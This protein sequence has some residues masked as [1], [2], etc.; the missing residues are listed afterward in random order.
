MSVLPEVVSI[1]F[2][3]DVVAGARDFPNSDSYLQ[4]WLR[5]DDAEQ[6]RRP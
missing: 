3:Q 4:S 2:R 5:P 6:G 1:E